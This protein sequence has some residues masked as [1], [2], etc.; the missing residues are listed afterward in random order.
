MNEV[1]FRGVK[2]ADKGKISRMIGNAFGDLKS[3]SWADAVWWRDLEGHEEYLFDDPAAAR[4]CFVATNKSK[5][6]G[7]GS[8]D[9]KFA[10]ETAFISYFCILPEFQRK[11]FGKQLVQFLVQRMKEERVSRVLAK[12]GRAHV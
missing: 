10:R 6:V 12:I 5:E 2:T 9:P 4:H 7:F 8:Y 1:Q 3:Q 11:G